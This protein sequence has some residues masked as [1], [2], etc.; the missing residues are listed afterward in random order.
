MHKIVI[1]PKVRSEIRKYIDAYEIY[2]ENLY[3]DSGLG[4][5]E[6]IIIDQYKQSAH[7]VS[8]AIYDAIEIV[9]TAEMIL[10]YSQKDTTTRVITSRIENRRIF[11]SYTE[12]E[13]ERIVTDIQIVYL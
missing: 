6:E 3:R 2:Y 8:M 1:S 12:S 10:G 11:L 13:T 5:A 7:A 9:F 4:I